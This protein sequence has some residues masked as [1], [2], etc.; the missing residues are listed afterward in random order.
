LPP[1]KHFFVALVENEAHLNWLEQALGSSASL[2]ECDEPSV[3]RM[4]QLVD[5]ASA[6]AVFVRFGNADQ[7]QRS[8][9]VLRMLAR[10]P[11]L[12]VIGLGECDDR[13]LVLSVLRSGA[14]DF[15][16][17][18]AP[19]VEVNAAVD[20]VL[21]RHTPIDASAALGSLHAMICARPDGYS[22]S[23]AAHLALAVRQ[24]VPPDEKVLLL[25]LGTPVGDSL[26]LLDLRPSYSFVDAVRSVRRFDQTLVHAV[27]AQHSS[28]LSVLT[29]PEDPTELEQIQ[30][31]D[32]I[33][34]IGVLRT[35]FDHVVLNLAG[36]FDLEQLVFMLEKATRLLVHT[37][38]C[39]ATCRANYR[40]LQALRQAK[41][42]VD[43]CRVVVDRYHPRIDPS[44]DQIAKLLE[45]ELWSCVPADGLR[46]LEAINSGKPMLELAPNS[47]YTR[48]I[49]QLAASLLDRDVAGLS[50][51]W[52]ERIWRQ[53]RS[54]RRAEG[55]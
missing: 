28:G 53:L 32:A 45:V 24:L 54:L 41:V 36:L 35:Y 1:S 13:D 42:S 14:R 2:V 21:A 16:P 52:L 9:F 55:G 33:A 7:A 22:A 31:A 51:G 15:L 8:Q 25:D 17:I 11:S 48:A 6:S 5:T 23:F 3:D 46:V 26:L 12:A 44:V 50:G 34:L 47:G 29:L 30:A 18:G 19:A 20:R 10:K 40:L 49:V 39:V 37:D 4:L 27:F 43:D 38:Q